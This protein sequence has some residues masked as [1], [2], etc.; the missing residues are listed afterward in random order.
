MEAAG[1]D[2]ST[3]TEVETAG[4]ALRSVLR[5]LGRAGGSA[6]AADA[7][8]RHWGG[9]SSGGGGNGR[10]GGHSG[11]IKIQIDRDLNRSIWIRR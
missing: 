2:A 6:D 9:G 10:E 3:P 1:A 11:I 8:L 5:L 4:E 7:L